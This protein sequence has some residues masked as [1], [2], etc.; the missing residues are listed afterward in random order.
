ML[1]DTVKDL[2]FGNKIF[3][4]KNKHPSSVPLRYKYST[5]FYRGTQS[6]LFEMETQGGNSYGKGEKKGAV[7]MSGNEKNL[8]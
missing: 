2:D 4:G 7:W 8:M 6:R 5:W 1:V 3:L